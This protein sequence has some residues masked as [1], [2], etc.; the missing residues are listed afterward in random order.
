MDDKLETRL[1]ALELMLGELMADA[2]ALRLQ[3]A[4]DR[5]RGGLPGAVDEREAAARRQALQHLDDALR[6]HDGFTVGGLFKLRG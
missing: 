6:R 1:A 5:I 3:A 2:D 4:M